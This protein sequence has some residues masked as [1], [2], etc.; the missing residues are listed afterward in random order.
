MAYK[1]PRTLRSYRREAKRLRDL[2]ERI[3]WV[4]PMFNGC[5][6]CSGCGAMRHHGCMEGCEVARV[7]GSRGK[8][9]GE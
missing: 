2:V 4:Q 5:D 3:Q 1:E 8:D 6:S 7:T 9:Q